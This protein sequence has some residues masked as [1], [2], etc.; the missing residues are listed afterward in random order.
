LRGSLATVPMQITRPTLISR[1]FGCG[2]MGQCDRVRKVGGRHSLRVTSSLRL[3]TIG[4]PT[5]KWD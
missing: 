3:R 4:P 5:I 2:L 1:S